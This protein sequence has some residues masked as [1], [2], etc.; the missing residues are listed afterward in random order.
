[1]PSSLVQEIEWYT[2]PAPV[3]YG[4][5]VLKMEERAT[6]VAQGSAPELVWLL[7]HPHVYTAGTSAKTSDVLSADCPVIQTGRG[8]QV[9]Y[10]GPGQRVVYVIL[11]L[12]KRGKDVR[13]Y[14][15]SLEEWIIQTLQQF[16]ITCSRR[17]GRIGLWVPR[18]DSTDDKIAAIGV[19]V[20]KWTTLHGIAINLNPDLNYYSGIVPCGITNHGVTSMHGLGRTISM[21]GLDEAL[22]MT[23]HRVFS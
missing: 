3:E 2:S 12:N 21:E 14:V 16:N 19:R 13:A 22:K 15:K 9:T 11:D 5:A 10:H 7:E 18:N 23:F 1:L 6:A 4:E 8:G 17:E 20:K